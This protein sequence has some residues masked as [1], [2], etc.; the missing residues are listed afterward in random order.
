MR[1]PRRLQSLPQIV[2]AAG[3]WVCAGIATEPAR[4]TDYD[5]RVFEG[6]AGWFVYDEAV[7]VALH[8]L[9]PADPKCHEVGEIILLFDSRAQ[10]RDPALI[11]TAALTGMARYAELCRA[12]G[13][14]PSN[15]RK[16]VSVVA[17][18]A[19]PD[20]R[21]RLIGEARI[22][23]AFVSSLTGVPRVAV[24]RNAAN[25]GNEKR[26]TVAIFSKED[27]KPSA[28]ERARNSAAQGRAAEIAE[29]RTTYDVALAESLAKAQ[30]PALAGR[31]IG[32]DR[33]RIA[34]VWAGS[35]AECANERLILFEANG[36]GKVEWWRT[37]N[38]DI[39]L[40]PWRAGKWDLR[41]GT[42]VMSLDHRVEYDDF[43]GRLRE[44]QV[45]ETLQFELMDVTHSAIRLAATG[46][47]LSPEALFLRGAEKLFVRCES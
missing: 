39:G 19:E 44:A 8:V 21:G 37:S 38:A 14:T 31:L 13:G 29:I 40:L 11:A 24:R 10:L 15:Q 26:D 6:G 36:T 9:R 3:L 17:G 33:A 41:R 47:G 28:G 46:G 4:A 20:T 30:S 18:E 25:T 12:L 16:V 35:Q 27:D 45:D 5:V 43:L 2:L 23:D 34:G 42:L 22:L 1:S 32:G 7:D